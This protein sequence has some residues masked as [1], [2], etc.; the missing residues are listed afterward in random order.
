[1]ALLALHLQPPARRWTLRRTGRRTA[2]RSPLSKASTPTTSSSWSSSSTSTRSPRDTTTQTRSGQ[3]TPRPGWAQAA[4]VRSGTPGTR[5]PAPSPV[6]RLAAGAKDGGGEH[7]LGTPDLPFH[8]KINICKYNICVI[9]R[10][11]LHND[12]LLNIVTEH[13]SSHK[14][15]PPYS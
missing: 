8:Y 13:G 9:F 15:T 1:M 10:S 2:G 4:R 12:R 5:H 7:C 11:Q 3:P 14:H 6:H